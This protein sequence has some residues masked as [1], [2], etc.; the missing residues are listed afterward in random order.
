MKTIKQ[1]LYI[2]YSNQKARDLKS[3]GNLN[4]LDKVITFDSLIEEIFEKSHFDYI[5]DDITATAILYKIIQDN[6]ISYFDYLDYDSLGLKTIYDFIIKCAR[7]EIEYENILKNERLSSLTEI[8]KYYIQYKNEYQLA[9]VSDVESVVCDNWSNDFLE[10]FDKV[11]IDR[12]EIG[13]INYIKS[14]KQ[15]LIFKNFNEC[16]KITIEINTHKVAKMMNVS[17]EVFD[18]IEEVKTSLKIV[19]KLMEEGE[20]SNNILIVASDIVEYAPIYKLFLNEYGLQ[21]YSSIGTPLSHFFDTC[22]Q[23]V[24][25]ALNS[26]K[27]EIVRLDRLYNRLDLKLKQSTKDNIKSNIT[28][29]D[30]KIGIEMTEPNQLVGLNKRYKHIIF[31]GTDINHFPPKANDNFL[32]SYEDDV[33]FFYANNYFTSSQTQYNELKK[34]SDNLYVITASYSGKRE[35]SRSIIVDDKIVDI[36]D[37]SGIRSVSELAVN[38]QTIREKSTED[39]YKSIT[40]KEFTKYDGMQMEE[41]EAK[42]LS[43]SQLTSYNSCPLKYLYS[44]KNSVQAP[45]SSEEDF[46]VMQ[47]GT[48]MH[49]CFESFGKQIQ[50]NVMSEDSFNDSMYSISIEEYT[51]FLKNE[52]LEENVYHKIFLSELQKGLKNDK[53]K[54]VLVKFV[55]YYIEN[56]EKFEHFKNS[57]FEKEFLLDNNLKPTSNQDNYFI[58]GFID[59]FDNLK[60]HINIIDYKSKKADGINSEMKMKI[61]ELKDFQLALYI[62]F[63]KQQYPDKIYNASLLTF[64][65]DKPYVEFAKISH[66][67]NEVHKDCV[68]FDD[69]YEETLV[70]KIYET[71]ENIISGKFNFDNSSEEACGYCDIKHIC[72]ERVLNKEVKYEC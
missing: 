33:K 51:K 15:E 38:S 48:L 37:V 17:N 1:D 11:F 32:Y 20:D 69:E 43:A 3:N 4:P 22:S 44:N 40:N 8:N 71:Q 28:L 65:S 58:K 27:A 49:S 42:H 61:E 14:K 63:A 16:E 59:R 36:F 25:S 5:I 24:I 23:K 62:L 39:Y 31:L 35:L 67:N 30:E 72:H 6:K 9:D 68:I 66:G 18:N 47:K 2:T 60:D 64:K 7:N 19:R 53:K 55:D 54:G 12:F 21:G 46:D 70:K 13:K 52:E 56:S 34:H 50:Q 29:L 26:Y 45:K 10:E 41:I 57:K